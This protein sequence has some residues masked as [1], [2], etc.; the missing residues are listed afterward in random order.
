M[1]IY[2][3]ENT[4]PI[5][6]H[7]P[8]GPWR[9]WI[10]DYPVGEGIERVPKYDLKGESLF[11]LYVDGDSME[12]VLSDRDLLIMNPELAFYANHKDK[13]GV[14]KYNSSYKIRKI[15]LM[16]DGNNYFLEPLN[17]LYDSEI[18]PVTGTTIFKIIE[19]RKHLG[20]LF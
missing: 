16:P 6:A 2:D 17:K 3:P 5:L 13:I 11:A 8:A 20:D 1:G 4:I 14:I 19:I 12:P 7:I 9:E 18:L 15:H 10:D